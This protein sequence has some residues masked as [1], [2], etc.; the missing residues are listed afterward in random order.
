MC[1]KLKAILMAI[2]LA[3]FASQQA[4]AEN[5]SEEEMAFAFGDATT[6]ESAEMVLLSDEEMMATE[7]EGFFLLPLYHGAKICYGLYRMSR[8]TTLAKYYMTRGSAVYGIYKGSSYWG[9]RKK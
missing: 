6:A 7:G 9:S 4:A 3:G 5:F 8:A 2:I 1:S